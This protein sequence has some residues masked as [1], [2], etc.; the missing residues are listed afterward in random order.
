ML[1]TKKSPS[2]DLG[3]KGLIKRNKEIERRREKTII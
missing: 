3:A 2:G 1:K